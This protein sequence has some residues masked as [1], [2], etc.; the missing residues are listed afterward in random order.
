[1]KRILVTGAGGFIGHHLVSHLK[2]LG[3]WVRGADIKYPEFS[4]VDADEF[5]VLDLRSASACNHAADGIDEIYHLA[6]DMGGIGWIKTH[7]AEILRNNLLIDLGMIDAARYRSVKK[8]LFSSSACVYPEYNQDVPDAA[9][10]KEHEVFPAQPEAA[11][12]WEKL[13]TEKLC[14][15]YRKDYK[16]DT[17]VTRFH[18]VYGPEETWTGG[19]EKVPAALSRKIAIAKRHGHKSIEVWGD[20]LQ[21]RSFIYVSD[22]V[23]GLVALMDSTFQEP[24]NI[25][26]DYT[27][28]VDE[29]A[30]RLIQIS[31]YPVD[32]EH[33]VG[34][35][36]V[37]GRNSD[38]TLANKVLPQWA[39][40]VP[41]SEGLQ[42]TY[43]WIEKQVNL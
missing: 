35:E 10:L 42:K 16:L 13:T 25:G 41:L 22:V 21:R 38:N 32:L 40:E 37:R 3:F 27:V 36:G 2:K 6:A 5:F 34:I 19:R 1:M 9:P 33:I 11:Y 30:H 7:H 24:V 28:S 43:L 15:Y 31:G 4:T 18:N 39:P 12:G 14:E 20:G 8:F 26:N 17:R 23:R 29:L